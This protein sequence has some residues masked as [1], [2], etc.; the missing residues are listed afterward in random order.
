MQSTYNKL[1]YQQ[2]QDKLKQKRKERYY[3]LNLHKKRGK[4]KKNYSLDEWNTLLTRR[5]PDCYTSIL[6]N[7]PSNRYRA[8]RKNAPCE[9][10][11]G[12]RLSFKKT[13]VRLT[14]Q[15][16]NNFKIEAQI[17]R[18]PITKEKLRKARIKQIKENFGINFPN[19][20]KK[21]CEFFNQLNTKNGWNLQHALNGG[22]VEIGG[23]FLDAYDSS[24]NIVIEYDE[25]KHKISKKQIAR[26]LEKQNIY[27]TN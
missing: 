12:E 14:K 16:R 19:F 20:N 15:E 13:G 23:Y 6:Y 27:A 9:K 8:D 21:A 11:Q 1:Y 5:C 18:I 7:N 4:L 25:L 3:L 2:N 26:D 24:L 10:C 17:K 22:E